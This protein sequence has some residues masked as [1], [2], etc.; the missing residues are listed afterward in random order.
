L[1]F[2]SVCHHNVINIGGNISLH[3][4][5][6]DGLR[7]PT[8]SGVGILEAFRHPEVTIGTERHDKAYFFFILFVELD[9]MVPRKTI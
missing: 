6:E 8:K 9:L 4:V 2:L 5:F 1:F 7:H 3:L